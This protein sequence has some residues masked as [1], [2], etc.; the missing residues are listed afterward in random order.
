MTDPTPAEFLAQLLRGAPEEPTPPTAPPG[1]RVPRPNRAQGTSG[2]SEPT[3]LDPA[4]L[5]AM[6]LAD[7][8]DAASGHPDGWRDIANPYRSVE[9]TPGWTPPPTTR[10]S[11]R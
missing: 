1:P 11:R 9:R 8:L 7:T 3:P 4:D 10:G 5:F 6:Q 2:I